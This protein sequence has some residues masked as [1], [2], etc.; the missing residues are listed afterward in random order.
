MLGYSCFG[1]TNKHNN[2]CTNANTHNRVCGSCLVM[3]VDDTVGI[4]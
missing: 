4:L 2:I 1:V 3:C